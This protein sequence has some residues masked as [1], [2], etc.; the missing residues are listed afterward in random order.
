M[1]TTFIKDGALIKRYL[2]GNTA[3]FETLVERH[4][5]R[6]Y[7]SVY[8][9]VK[10]EYLAEDIFQETFIKIIRNIRAGKYNHEDKF[11]PWAL[12]IAR[13]MAI[14]YIRKTKR[15]PTI[16]TCDGSGTDLFE[17]INI[18]EKSQEQLI[19]EN[20]D[21]KRLHT[22]IHALPA[23]QK[24]VLILRSYANLSFKEIAEVTQ[25]NINTCI[26]RMHY[27]ITNLRKMMEKNSVNVK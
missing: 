6:I 18:H 21:H 7:G 22:W 19:I 25:S 13:N 17:T 16:I 3:S 12:R 2:E 10:D 9:V 5:D 11:L 1:S 15:M 27:A 8:H 23:E 24:E 14:D 20:E 26:G 4:K